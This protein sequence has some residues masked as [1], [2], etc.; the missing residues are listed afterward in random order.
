MAEPRFFPPPP[1]E[2]LLEI[3]DLLG[4]GFYRSDLEGRIHCI[5]ACGAAC[6]GLTP[7]AIQAGFRTRDFDSGSYDHEV[8]RRQ[9][10][11]EGF[12][13]FSTTARRADGSDFVVQSSIRRLDDAEGRFAG[14]EG[15]FRDVTEDARLCREQVRLLEEVRAANARLRKMSLLQDRLLS[16]LAHDLVTPPVVMQGFSELLLKGRYGPLA[17]EQEKP[18]RTIQRNLGL[19]SEMVERLLT[20]TRLIRT[21]QQEPREALSLNA[22]WTEALSGGGRVPD[23]AGKRF[24]RRGPEA[25][26]PLVAV[27]GPA[28]TYLLDN[29]SENALDL[30]SPEVPIVW[31]TSDT[32]ALG[33]LRLTLAS[34]QEDAP[35]VS[36]VLERFYP[37][38]GAL[39]Q[40]RLAQRGLGLAAARYVAAAVGG[41]LTAETGENGALA[42]TLTLPEG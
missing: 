32:G 9:V 40:P 5:N 16:A 42:L 3:L 1:P 10:E 31:S 34:L 36:K 12:A 39:C 14:Y 37:E 33:V 4:I 11:S 7:E 29:L 22:A 23:G 38:P 19:L 25:G 20:F 13:S 27:P 24:A 26:G 8:I 15:V 17:P 35:P 6:F 2:T 30:A 28:L 41:D 21:L 18:L